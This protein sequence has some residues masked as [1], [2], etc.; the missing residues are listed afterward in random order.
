MCICVWQDDMTD[1]HDKMTWS[2]VMM[3][4]SSWNEKAKTFDVNVKSKGAVG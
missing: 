3:L 4:E 1:R 2:C